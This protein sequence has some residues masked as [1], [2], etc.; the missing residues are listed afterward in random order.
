[1][2]AASKKQR[3]PIIKRLRQEGAQAYVDGNRGIAPQRYK[4]TANIWQWLRGYEEAKY[5][6]NELWKKKDAERIQA[7][8]EERESYEPF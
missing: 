4:G 5:E 3:A 2:G 8:K 7:E 6:Y 1:M